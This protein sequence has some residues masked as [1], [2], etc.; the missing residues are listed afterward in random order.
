MP[1]T[2]TVAT[3]DSDSLNLITIADNAASL[4]IVS[5]NSTILIISL[6]AK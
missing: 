1:T 2:I 3:E 6:L 4:N 5:I